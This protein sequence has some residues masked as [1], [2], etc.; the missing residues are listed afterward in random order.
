L[1]TSA[2]GNSTNFLANYFCFNLKNIWTRSKNNFALDRGSC[3]ATKL[4]WEARLEHNRIGE[5]LS[6]SDGWEHVRTLCGVSSWLG[7]TTSRLSVSWPL[8]QPCHSGHWYLTCSK[9]YP[10]GR[11]QPLVCTQRI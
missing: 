3:F 9:L 2:K 5:T 1:V 4:S 6:W 7:S 11:Q 10:R 8:E